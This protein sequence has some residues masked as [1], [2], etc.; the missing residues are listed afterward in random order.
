[1]TAGRPTVILALTPIAEHQVELL[2]F[3]T[4]S[5]LTLLSSAGEA[6]ELQRSVQEEHPQA[7]LISPELSGLT[8]AHC[9]RIRVAGARLVGLALGDR[10]RQALARLGV[11][12]T[13]DPSVSS[14]ELRD[15][16]QGEQT[17]THAPTR[18]PPQL[19]RH[20]E[21][22]G[23]I[24]AVV[25]SK[26][27]PGASE[28]AASLAALAGRRWA[29]VL[30]E[31]DAL[32]GGLD[33]RLGADAR[34]GS[35]LG[36]IRAIQTGEKLLRE[37]LERWLTER[38][39]W[40]AVLLAPPDH[41]ASGELAA[42]G[43]LTRA[44]HALA[45][46]YPLAVC[47]VGFLLRDGQEVPASARIHREALV[48]ADAVVLIFGGRDVQVRE[49]LRQLDLL[50]DTLGVVPERL[51]I[52]ANAIGGP[53]STSRAA[54]TRSLTARLAERGVTVDAWLPWDDRGLKRA[55]RGGT[56]LAVARGRGGYAR[57][58]SGLLDELFLP[59]STSMPTPKR[60]KRRLAAP[61]H[62]QEPRE[63]EVALPWQS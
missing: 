45:A 53:G 12:R 39:G 8:P 56:P 51:R 32:G 40:P 28:C 49:G 61:G 7:V 14:E 30:V 42:P 27:A 57:A 46:L 43:V 13:I 36:L 29:T 48:S 6:D 55:Q 33:V 15:A 54:I 22:D 44:L 19:E 17:Q 23:S 31:V 63:E 60:R 24:V 38:E 4:D 21:E 10:E 52:I 37:L 18:A 62:P 34:E 11:D 50:L 20:G 25:G 2:L 1:M 5:P 35:L 3:D 16:I 9:E 47:D 26:G 41:D 59:A 58:L